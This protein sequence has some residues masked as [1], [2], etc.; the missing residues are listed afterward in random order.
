MVGYDSVKFFLHLLDLAGSNLYV[1]CLTLHAA[2]RL[3][4]HNAAM[5]QGRALALLACHQQYSRHAGC[6]TRADGGNGA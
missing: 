6:H 4:Y 5:R 3:M 2:Q 1:T